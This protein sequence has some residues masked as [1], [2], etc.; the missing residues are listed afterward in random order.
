LQGSK[1]AKRWPLNFQDCC[2]RYRRYHH[3]GISRL[4][5]EHSHFAET[6]LR[7]NS[8]DLA[9]FPLIIIDVHVKPA[10]NQN[11]KG[12]ASPVALMDDL[13]TRAVNKQ[14]CIRANLLA[15]IVPAVNN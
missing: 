15:R 6:C 13:F 3:G 11:V 5:G 14:T 1:S 10:I 12:V 7:L 4:P 8:A 2:F 9:A